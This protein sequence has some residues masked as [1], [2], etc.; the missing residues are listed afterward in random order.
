[1]QEAGKVLPGVRMAQSAYDAAR[2]AD[3]LVVITEWSEFRGL[4]PIRLRQLMRVPRIVDLRNIFDP[5]EMR[6]LGFDYVCVG[7]PANASKDHSP[8]AG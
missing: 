4:D 7:R 6:D 1:M 3:V 8:A 5:D 2:T